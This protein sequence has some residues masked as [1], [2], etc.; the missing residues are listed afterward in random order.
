[1]ICDRL[2]VRG[3]VIVIVCRLAGYTRENGSQKQRNHS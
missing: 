3:L 1:L 2:F